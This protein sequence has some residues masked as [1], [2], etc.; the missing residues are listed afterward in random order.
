MPAD[1]P[2]EMTFGGGPVVWAERA[3]VKVR[4][5]K[6]AVRAAAIGRRDVN[7][8]GIGKDLNQVPVGLLKTSRIFSINSDAEKGLLRKD[9][10]GSRTPF[11]TMAFSV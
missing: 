1:F 2:R 3:I 11:W 4:A 9:M 10:L 6:T 5:M 7:R 8:A